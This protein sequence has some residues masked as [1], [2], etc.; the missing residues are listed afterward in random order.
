MSKEA[1]MITNESAIRKIALTGNI[2]SGKTTIARIFKMLQVE[3]YNADKEAH[4]IL[5]YGTVKK[6]LVDLFGQKVIIQNSI[7]RK[8]L[9]AIVFQ[10]KTMLEKLNSII[11]PMVMK[12]FEC[13][14]KKLHSPKPY[15]L[16][17]S[18][19]IFDAGLNDFFDDVILVTA[20]QQIRVKRCALR[21]G[22][23]QSKIWARIQHQTPEKLLIKKVNH[24]IVND[25]KTMVI[26]QVLKL[27]KELC[28]RY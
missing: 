11:H 28:L 4:K 5:E 14:M 13:W 10:D 23:T 26:P 19:I 17:E 9:A 15:I 7:N 22:V 3:V 24:R 12:D 8:A 27:D 20:P 18:A 1:S 21:D 25:G 16:F 6:Q 2:G